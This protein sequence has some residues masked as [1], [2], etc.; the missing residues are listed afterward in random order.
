[1]C[2][3]VLKFRQAKKQAAKPA[4]DAASQS[5]AASTTVH[6]APPDSSDLQFWIG[7]SG[8][9]YIHTVHSLINCPEVPHVNYLLVRKEDCGFQTVLAAGHTTHHAAS[10]NLAEIRR[11]GATLGANEVHVHMLAGDDRQAK[12]IEHDLRASQIQGSMH[13]ASPAH[14]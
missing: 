4:S 11:L 6:E 5:C 14:H 8:A 7:A 10:L 2:A 9:R 3:Q 12:V 1:M 13:S